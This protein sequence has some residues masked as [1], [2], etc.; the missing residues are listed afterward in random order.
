[1]EGFELD[2]LSGFAIERWKP[3]LI[4]IEDHVLNLAKHRYLASHGYRLVRR[5]GVNAWY[6]PR[7]RDFPLDL[8]GRWQLF[9]KYVVGLP[10]RKLR[11]VL[12]RRR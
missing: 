9:R 6:I 8:H 2:V 1:V 12:G 11:S 7:D 10:F 5:T 4:L 3:G